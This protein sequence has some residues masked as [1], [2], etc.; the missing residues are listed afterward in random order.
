M[1]L[2]IQD[3]DQ[4]PAAVN[5]EPSSPIIVQQLS[6]FQEGLYTMELVYLVI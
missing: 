4:W 3:R 1:D 6:A 5:T 2:F